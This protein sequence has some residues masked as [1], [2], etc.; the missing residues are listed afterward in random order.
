[1]ILKAEYFGDVLQDVSNLSSENDKFAQVV[2]SRRTT[3]GLTS[4]PTVGRAPVAPVKTK[5]GTQGNRLSP[6]LI[7]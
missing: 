1:M 2:V 7:F 6:P 3:D 4:L 5:T